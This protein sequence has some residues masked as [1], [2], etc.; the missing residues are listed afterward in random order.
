[1]KA[2]CVSLYLLAILAVS[3]SCGR[4]GDTLSP[5]KLPSPSP[6]ANPTAPQAHGSRPQELRDAK[7]VRGRLRRVEAASVIEARLIELVDADGKEWRF[8]VAGPLNTTPGHLNQHMLLGESVTVYYRE[9][10]GGL[11]AVYVTD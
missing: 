11:E 8:D 4:G 5:T 10:G 1:M 7:S 3:L 9:S 2:K 6:V